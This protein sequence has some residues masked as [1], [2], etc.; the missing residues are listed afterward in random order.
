MRVLRVKGK[1]GP[2]KKGEVKTSFGPI[3]K[4]KAEKAPVYGEIR[5]GY[6]SPTWGVGN[7]PSGGAVGTGKRG[8][9]SAMY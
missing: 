1:K 4:A 6:A 5:S 3:T 2:V 9:K 8:K 7:K